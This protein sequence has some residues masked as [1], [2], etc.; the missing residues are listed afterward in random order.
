L[1]VVMMVMLVLVVLV[2]LPMPLVMVLVIFG[3]RKKRKGLDDLF[4]LLP[5]K[6]RSGLFFFAVSSN[7][8]LKT[9]LMRSYICFYLSIGE[10]RCRKCSGSLGAGAGGA[11]GV[12]G[13]GDVADAFVDGAVDIRLSKKMERARRL[14]YAA[15]ETLTIYPPHVTKRVV[16]LYKYLLYLHLYSN[17]L[18]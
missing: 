7:V 9:A 2:M 1:L 16:L 3:F 6:S 18:L 8:S 12:G 14:V 13:G 4:M 10:E 11:G 5:L 17:Y 15:T